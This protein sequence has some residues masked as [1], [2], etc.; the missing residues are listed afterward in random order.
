MKPDAG[1]AA[2]R[3]GHFTEQHEELPASAGY[4]LLYFLSPFPSITVDQYV[5]MDV[6]ASITKMLMNEKQLANVLTFVY[7]LSSYCFVH[8]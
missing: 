1:W 2:G 3:Q 7:W 4:K 8:A 6:T 5:S